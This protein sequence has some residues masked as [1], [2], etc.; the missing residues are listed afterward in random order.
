MRTIRWGAAVA[1]AVL[2]VAGLPAVASGRGVPECT[3][4]ELVAS[5]HR[6]GRA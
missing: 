3:N 2:T 1:V 4:A 6:A 5:Y